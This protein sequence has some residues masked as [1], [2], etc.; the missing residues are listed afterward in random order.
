MP[1]SCQAQAPGWTPEDAGV[2]DLL[3]VTTTLPLPFVARLTAFILPIWH[4]SEY[5]GAG[6]AAPNNGSTNA[7]ASA[8]NNGFNIAVTSRRCGGFSSGPRNAKR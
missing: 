3:I 6:V 5:S 7:M 8:A 4:V 2:G 1:R